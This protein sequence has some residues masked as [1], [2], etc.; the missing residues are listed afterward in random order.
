MFVERPGQQDISKQERTGS[1]SF[2][3][4]DTRSF[5][6]GQGAPQTSDH[7]FL[8][9][10]SASQKFPVLTD[11]EAEQWI[12]DGRLRVSSAGEWVVE[13]SICGFWTGIF[14]ARKK[15][16]GFQCQDGLHCLAQSGADDYEPRFLGKWQ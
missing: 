11:L 7:P 16:T 8:Q 12:K 15:G 13:C 4:A 9:Q 1:L 3:S 6:S 2:S 10:V 14:T 5:N